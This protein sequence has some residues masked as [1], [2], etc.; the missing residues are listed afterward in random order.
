MSLSR[1][2][3]HWQGQMGYGISKESIQALSI[4]SSHAQF[5]LLEACSLQAINFLVEEGDLPQQMQSL[6]EKRGDNSQALSNPEHSHETAKKRK[7]NQ[8]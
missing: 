3:G 2:W 8:H 1:G 6:K 5:L 4:R 7:K